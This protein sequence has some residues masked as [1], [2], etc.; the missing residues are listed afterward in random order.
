MCRRD[1]VG[2]VLDA[3]LQGQQLFNAQSAGLDV[4]DHQVQCGDAAFEGT[5]QRVGGAGEAAEELR[6]DPAA[7][8]EA[9]GRHHAQGEVAG[10]RAV[11]ALAEIERG[12]RRIERRALPRQPVDRDH[13]PHRRAR[14]KEQR[15]QGEE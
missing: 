8:E 10:L 15:Q 4:S 11:E 7:E 9:A 13:R 3:A 2:V 5:E 14:R 6:R 12:E 1:S